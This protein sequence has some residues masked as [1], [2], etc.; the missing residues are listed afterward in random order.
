[1]RLKEMRRSKEYKIGKVEIDREIEQLTRKYSIPQTRKYI[2]DLFTTVIK[3]HLDGADSRDLYMANV[4]LKELRHIFRVFS[5]YRD[6][7]K[8]VIF[9]SHRSPKS[10]KEYKI[11]QLFSR[12]MVKQGY[13]V[14]TGGGGGVMEAGNRGAGKNGFAVKIKLPAEIEPNPYVSREKLINVNYFYTRKLAFIKESDAT[15]LFPGGFG[16]HDE[17]FEV[18]T[19]LQTGKAAPRPLVLIESPGEDYWKTWLA[20]LKEKMIKGGFL[21]KEDLALFTIV[22]SV[23]EA[24]EEITRFYRNYHSIRFG[25]ELTLIRLNRQISP[26]DLKR[27]GQKYTDILTAELRPC[28]PLPAEV[29]AKELLALPRICLQYNRRSYGRLVALIKDLNNY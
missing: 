19:L 1:M 23:D 13:M 12:K 21:R 17:G 25:K 8:V 15:A 26:K 9:G 16:T 2:H 10:S 3:L 20:F 5:R 7:R 14:I 29:R 22:N 24:V 27:L 18:L 11:A 6:V 4:T 28:G